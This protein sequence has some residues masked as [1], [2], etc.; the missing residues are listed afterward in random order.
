MPH[1]EWSLTSTLFSPLIIIK[2]GDSS[3]GKELGSSICPG[4]RNPGLG[5]VPSSPPF[6]GRDHTTEPGHLG[7][8]VSASLQWVQLCEEPAPPLSPLSPSC[9][10]GG[11]LNHS[12]GRVEGWKNQLTLSPRQTVRSKLASPHPCLLFSLVLCVVGV[13]PPAYTCVH[14]MHAVLTEA[15][16]GH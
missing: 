15:R 16:R 10:L 7:E 4:L 11:H 14:H 3:Q 12:E 8:V 6:T 9:C 5:W 13:L 1:L 2:A